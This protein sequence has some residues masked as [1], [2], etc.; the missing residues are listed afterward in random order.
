MPPPQVCRLL[1]DKA[2]PEPVRGH[3]VQFLNLLLTQVGAACCWSYDCCWWRLAC[4]PCAAAQQ[5]WPVTLA[6]G[7]DHDPSCKSL[8]LATT[9][10][11]VPSCPLLQLVPEL[12]PPDAIP[13][14]PSPAP[15]S[16]APRSP[17]PGGPGGDADAAP[18]SSP[19]DGQP[20]LQAAVAAGLEAAKDAVATVLGREARAMLLV[21]CCCAVWPLPEVCLWLQLWLVLPGSTCT[22]HAHS[23]LAN[24]C[25]W[26]RSLP[27]LQ[28][29]SAGQAYA[30]PLAAPPCLC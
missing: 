9:A 24:G 29:V 20:E 16:P 17:A 5:Q 8:L 14:T 26:L 10:V 22:Q 18:A 1:R 4:C 3:A 25:R 19:T 30:R 21:S 12:L 27:I 23:L 13:P 2:T 28:A 6:W 11:S 7:N 15:L